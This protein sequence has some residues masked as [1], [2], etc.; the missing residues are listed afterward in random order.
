MTLIYESIEMWASFIEIIVL[1]KIYGAMIGR[2]KHVSIA[3]LEY[4]W[5]VLGMLLMQGC[6]RISVFSYFTMLVFVLYVSL[7]ALFMY[8]A[9]YVI[10]FS[11][12]CFYLL[13]LS[14]FDFLMFTLVSNVF[15]GYQTFLQLI[16]VRGIYRS[17]IIIAIKA[18]WI[19]A[20]A[21]LKKYLY[22]FTVKKNHIY[23]I[24]VIAGLGFLG[25][26]Y[27]VNQTFQALHSITAVWFIFIACVALVLFT[28]YFVVEFREEK[29]KLNFSEMRNR[30]LEEKYESIREIYRSNAKLYHD[31]NNHLNVLYQLLEENHIN[32][33]KEYIKEISRP[34]TQLTKSSWTGVDV[35]DVILNSKL[36]IMKEKSISAEVNVEF[37][38]NTNILPHDICTILANLLDNAIEAVDALENKGII[39]ITIRKINHFLAIK[40]SNDCSEEG[41]KFENYPKTTK[42]DKALHGWGLPGVRDAV[43]KY[44]GTM[45]CSYEDKRFVIKILLFFEADNGTDSI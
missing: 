41:N 8:E 43:E 21:F 33:A 44:N 4:L 18:L 42:E 39:S 24:L 9:S 45:N 5:A 16:S 25:F 35:V 29:M 40:I 10:L 23:H 30:L 36:E 7:S 11:I 37:P 20:F 32:E 19:C 27:L 17:A 31:L 13:C 15:E 6:N 26:I 28:F 3:Y 22:R 1:Y 12:A 14:C 34:M 2:K 38:Q